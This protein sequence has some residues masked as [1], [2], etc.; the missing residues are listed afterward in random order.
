MGET[1][2]VTTTEQT[3][4]ILGR[5]V[6][7][8]RKS[9][10][11][12]HNRL[13]SRPGVLRTAEEV[14][15]TPISA[16]KIRTLPT[17]QQQVVTEAATE[18]E[19]VTVKNSEVETPVQRKRHR[20]PFSPKPSVVKAAVSEDNVIN[21][22]DLVEAK[23]TTPRSELKSSPLSPLSPLSPR[24]SFRSLLKSRLQNRLSISVPIITMKDKRPSLPVTIPPV[25]LPEPVVPEPVT[26]S[27]SLTVKQIPTSQSK[28]PQRA[29]VETV[30]SLPQILQ[31]SRRIFPAIIEPAF[32][33]PAPTSAP[34][35]TIPPVALFEEATS[36][37]TVIRSRLENSVRSRSRARGRSNT[38]VSQDEIVRVEPILEPERFPKGGSSF[39]SVP[40]DNIAE[41]ERQ[42]IIAH[43]VRNQIKDYLPEAENEGD[44]YEKLRAKIERIQ[45]RNKARGRG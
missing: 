30:E 5:V 31:P 33:N 43:K 39:V 25:H 12:T 36:E 29:G 24:K 1:V 16:R 17:T 28:I 9:L 13:R 8:G 40:L 11:S 23:F 2:E 37:S 22:D 7:T 45:N 44:A 27:H 19:V 32:I 21:T 4:G 15:T 38:F 14:A 20:F 35:V 42:R 41:G 34:Q 18:A 26:E 6:S 10:F 3:Q